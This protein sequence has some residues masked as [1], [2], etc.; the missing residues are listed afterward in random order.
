MNLHPLAYLLL[1][2]LNVQSY[3]IPLVSQISAPHSDQYRKVIVP[4]GT[5]A[6]W[7]KQTLCFVVWACLIIALKHYYLIRCAAAQAKI[8]LL[9]DY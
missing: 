4:L 6:H 1:D 8:F 7:A 2:H 9:L 5:H 3:L